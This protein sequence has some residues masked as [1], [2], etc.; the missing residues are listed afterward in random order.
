MRLA[1]VEE[2]FEVVSSIV[3]G[4][5]ASITEQNLRNVHGIGSSSWGLEGVN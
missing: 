5:G 3:A 2:A 4:Q 1:E